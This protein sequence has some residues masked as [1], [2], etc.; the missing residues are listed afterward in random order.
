[1]RQN[2]RRLG[3]ANYGEPLVVVH[4]P[5]PGTVLEVP[6]GVDASSG[7]HV[8]SVDEEF[9]WDQFGYHEL[10]PYLQAF[11]NANPNVIIEKPV[12][13]YA[14]AE[15]TVGPFNLDALLNP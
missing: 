2:Y 4:N 12:G 14:E 13:T 7:Y 10:N 1:M 9:A 6:G 11:Q 8:I 3:K 15:N 5:E